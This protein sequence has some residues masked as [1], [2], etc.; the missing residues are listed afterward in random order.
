MHDV[1]DVVAEGSRC[2]VVVIGAGTGGLTAAALLARAG[3][4]VTVLEAADAIGGVNRP[5][6]VGAATVAPAGALVAD[7]GLFDAI[8]GH[9]GMDGP[10]RLPVDVLYHGRAGD[11]AVTAPATG[12]EPFIAANA[13]AVSGPAADEVRVMLGMAA[14]VHRQSHSLPQRAGLA[15]VD[16]LAVR[17]PLAFATRRRT[18]AQQMVGVVTDPDAAALCGLPS[19]LAGLAPSAVAMQT[20]AQQLCSFLVDGATTFAGG[21][22]AWLGGLAATVEAAGGTVATDTAVAQV[23]GGPDPWVVTAEGARIDARAVVVAAAMPG[24]TRPASGR[25]EVGPSAVVLLAEATGDLSPL[26]GA[27][28]ALLA[29]HDVEAAI[30]EG[31]LPRAVLLRVPSTVDPGLAPA[32]HHALSIVGFVG[33]GAELPADDGEV[34]AALLDRVRMV[35]PKLQVLA[36]RL[37]RPADLSAAAGEPTGAAFGWADTPRANRRP[38]PRTATPGVYL[39]GKWTRPGGCTLRTTLSGIFTSRLVLA[40]LGVDTPQLEYANLPPAR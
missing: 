25:L 38:D 28:L 3:L 2:D 36:S 29:D 39:A 40:D 7:V 31:P 33:V 4:S 5:W 23:H 21:V 26:G 10:A 15:E 12:V 14:E 11:V 30:G 32:G 1:A 24:G 22:N 19:M 18:L 27:P 9:L 16:D 17:F 8:A 6:T 20:Y 37:L 34:A 35:V 13:A